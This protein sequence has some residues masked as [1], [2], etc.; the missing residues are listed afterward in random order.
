MNR[1]RAENPEKHRYTLTVT[2]TIE[3]WIRIRDQ[4][5]DSSKPDSYVSM[6]FRSE[7]GDMVSQAKKIYW[8]ENTVSEGQQE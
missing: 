8:P 6:A 2:Y 4:L 5:S 1:F 3:E 7:I